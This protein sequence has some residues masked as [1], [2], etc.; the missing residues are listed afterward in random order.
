[1][2]MWKWLESIMLGNTGNALACWASLGLWTLNEKRFFF[3]V[4]VIEAWWKL[5]FLDSFSVVGCF[6][7]RCSNTILCTAHSSGVGYSAFM[8][9][10]IDSFEYQ[11]GVNVFILAHS[12][13]ICSLHVAEIVE[14]GER[15]FV[16]CIDVFCSRV[17]CSMVINIK[18]IQKKWHF[19][20]LLWFCYWWNTRQPGIKTLLVLIWNMRLND[21]N[22]A[23]VRNL[24]T[25]I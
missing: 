23:H 13:I 6:F 1:M 16:I 5:L 24:F 11:F 3:F 10:T 17:W 8:L 9:D 14:N 18:V 15:G 20:F 21:L 2:S 22:N 4:W 19:F 12:N 25:T 7:F